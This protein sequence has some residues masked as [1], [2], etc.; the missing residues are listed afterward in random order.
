MDL[1]FERILGS[2]STVS[3]FD[4]LNHG[5]SWNSIPSLG[6][7]PEWLALLVAI[8]LLPVVTIVAPILQIVP[9]TLQ[10][11]Y[12]I[13]LLTYRGLISSV[14]SVS[15]GLMRVLSACVQILPSWRHGM[16][17]ALL[18]STLAPSQT[19]NLISGS[20]NA[21]Q[22]ATALMTL[23]SSKSTKRSNLVAF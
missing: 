16:A 6:G 4:L 9:L 2:L 22:D 7:V 17:L 10:F 20:I 13:V 1:N 8:R 21:V 23:N 14:L 15:H 12:S 19:R 5:N 3:A 11:I 18:L